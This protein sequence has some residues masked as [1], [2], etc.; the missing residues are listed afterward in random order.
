MPWTNGGS[1]REHHPFRCGEAAELLQPISLTL[2]KYD[3]T[4]SV[5]RESLNRFVA[6]RDSCRRTYVPKPPLDRSLKNSSREKATVVDDIA[7]TGRSRWEEQ[8]II[9]CQLDI[10]SHHHVC[11]VDETPQV[12]ML[13]IPCGSNNDH[14]LVTQQSTQSSIRDWRPLL[15]PGLERIE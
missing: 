1:D 5:P 4:H 12:T 8:L 13:G 11:A 14:V 10:R 7:S 2:C 9:G 15:L 3:R 6:Q